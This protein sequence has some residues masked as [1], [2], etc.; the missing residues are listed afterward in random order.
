[1]IFST[2]IFIF[3]FLP[4][5]LAVYYVSPRKFKNTSLFLASLVFYAWGEPVYVSIMLFSTVFD[6]VN[7]LFIEKFK[8]QN[9]ITKSKIILIISIVGNLSILFFFK[10]SDFVINNINQLFSLDIKNLDLKLPIGISFYTFQTMSYT[11][12]VYRG[13]VKAQKNII[14]FGTFV[15]LFPQLVAGPIVRYKTIAEQLKSRVHSIDKFSEGVRRFI[16]GL[17]KKV[18]LAN[19]IG[20]IWEQISSSNIN[21]LP[22]SSAW[23]GAICF[24][25]QIYFDFSG[26]SDMAIGLG[27]M[28]GFDFLENF[29]L[30]YISKSITEFWRRWHISLGT[31]F[32]EYVYIPL[33]G[34]RKGTKKLIRNMFIVWALTGFWHGANWNFVFWGIYFGIILIMEKLFLLELLQKLPNSIKHLYTLF[35]V[36]ISWVIFSIE[37]TAMLGKY[38]KAMFGLNSAPIMNNETIYLFCTNIFLIIACIIAVTNLPTYV[39]NKLQKFRYINLLYTCKNICYLCIFVVSISFLIGASY[40]PFLYFRF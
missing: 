7:G 29:N 4:C 9:K 36:I 22:L 13:K 30:P 35:L 15:S 24:S 39:N 23:L 5:I 6:F 2:P 25:L 26:Y 19:N 14:D 21:N 38:L 8:L 37:D 16:I 32:K 40:N 27:K 34:S 1:M 18:L 11:I 10:Y 28:L 33:G 3:V 12:D 31:W 17:G 20:M